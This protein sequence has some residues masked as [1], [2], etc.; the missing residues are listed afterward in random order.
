M[1]KNLGGTEGNTSLD[2][3][4]VREEKR[5]LRQIALE[6]RRNLPDR[7]ER[8]L[9]IWEKIFRLPEFHQA[10]TIACYVALPEE[11]QTEIGLRRI[12]EEGKRLVVP[13]C[14]GW[15]LE[16]CRILSLDELSPGHWGIGEPREELRKHLA[17]IVA[18]DEVDLFVVPGVAF[19]RQGGRLGFGKGY[20]DRLL[21]RAR[22][23]TCR[24]GVCFACQL[25][26]KVPQLPYDVRMNIL[27]T[28]EEL[29]LCNSFC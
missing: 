8:S 4:L 24:M 20:F 14:H 21:R 22:E 5:R 17:R 2:F 25:F 1:S 13:Y 12:L 10:G 28:E 6:R 3:D 15:D 18:A 11:V 27:I 29:F 19:D 7:W 9:Q 16:L 23:G 26:D